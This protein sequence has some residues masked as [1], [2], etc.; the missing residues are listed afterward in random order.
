MQVRHSVRDNG[1]LNRIKS[2]LSR[3]NIGLNENNGGPGYE[4]SSEDSE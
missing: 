3:K 1:E 2:G 4:F